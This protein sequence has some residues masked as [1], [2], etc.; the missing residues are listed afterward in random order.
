MSTSSPSRVAGRRRLEDSGTSSAVGT[1]AGAGT[2]ST[3]RCSW[4]ERAP[5]LALVGVVESS[6]LAGGCGSELVVGRGVVD[7]VRSRLWLRVTEGGDGIGELLGRRGCRSG[8]QRIEER[9]SSSTK[10]G[11]G[12]GGCYYMREGRGDA[13]VVSILISASA[14]I[15]PTRWTGRW[16]GTLQAS[17]GE[18]DGSRCGGRACTRGNDDAGLDKSVSGRWTRARLA[19]VFDGGGK[20]RRLPATTSQ[21]TGAGARRSCRG[22]GGPGREMR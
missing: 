14:S 21:G 17:K 1:G 22:E 4:E 16:L 19:G 10:D 5:K 9:L 7:D 18:D 3:G 6:I 12:E 8:G 2:G 15:A 13:M 20:G 11:A